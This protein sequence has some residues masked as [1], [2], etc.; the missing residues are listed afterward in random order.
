MSGAI[1]G[2]KADILTK[3]P[4]QFE[5]KNEEHWEPKAYYKQAQAGLNLGSGRT[6]VVVMKS[7]NT[8]MFVMMEAQDW[9]NLL[10]AAI[11]KTG[12]EGR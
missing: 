9:I 3:L 1:A 5:C 11:N 2:M 7:N 8:P 6:P 10:Y 12:Y 4:F